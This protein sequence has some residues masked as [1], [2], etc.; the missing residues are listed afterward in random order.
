MS[1]KNTIVLNHKNCFTKFKRISDLYLDFHKKILKLRSN[2]FLVAVS[3]GPDSLALSAVCKILS[4]NDK[5]KK[6]HYVHINHG[7]RKNSLKEANYVKKILAKQR[8]SLKVINNR[9]NINRNIQHNARKIRYSLLSKECNKKK[10]KYILVAHHKYDQI[11]TFFIRLSR[12]SGVQGLSAMNSS[13]T[14]EKKIKVFRPFLAV[15]KKELVAVSKIVFDDYIKDPSNNNNK[16]LRTNV[17]KL[18]PLLKRHGIK[19]DQII[20]SINNLKSS[21]E[22]IKIYFNEI[23]KKI[24]KKKKGN[25]L[26]TKRVLFSLNNELQLRVLGSVIKSVTKSYYPPRSQKILT[27]LNFFNLS[28]GNKYQLGGCWLISGNNYLKVQKIK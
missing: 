17:R 1:K 26:I 19:E 7:I 12:G 28:H 4:L 8:I 6:F 13:T 16:Y 25:F 18:L 5:T 21:N 3:G 9:V 27:A 11:E 24:V 15:Q 10:I 20:K 23:F 2:K 14:V 22:T